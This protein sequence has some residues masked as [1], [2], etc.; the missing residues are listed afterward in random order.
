MKTLRRLHHLLS[1]ALALFA[2]ANQISPST[3]DQTQ[4]IWDLVEVAL[5]RERSGPSQILAPTGEP[6]ELSSSG[7]ILQPYM[8]ETLPVSQSSR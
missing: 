3:P 1:I 4:G 5:I 2:F 6:M 8:I 7:S